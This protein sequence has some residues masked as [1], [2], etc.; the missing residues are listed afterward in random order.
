MR[1]NIVPDVIQINKDFTNKKSEQRC[2]DF[3]IEEEKSNEKNG[4]DTNRVAFSVDKQLP[5]GDVSTG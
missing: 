2:P 5:Y 3:F 1:L 4:M